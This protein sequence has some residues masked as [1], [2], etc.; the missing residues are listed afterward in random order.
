MSSVE[1]VIRLD[2]A[3]LTPKLTRAGR[4]VETGPLKVLKFLVQRLPGDFVFKPDFTVGRKRFGRVKRC[5]R[6]VNRIW[7]FIVLIRQGRP[8]FSTKCSDDEGG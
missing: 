4:I 7:T 3:L 8:T 2:G 5:G 6:H 1:T